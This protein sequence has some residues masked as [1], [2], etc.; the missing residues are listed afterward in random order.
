MLPRQV[1]T[2]K[3]NNDL[4]QSIAIYG[5]VS[6]ASTSSPLGK[7]RNWQGDSNCTLPYIRFLVFF[8]FSKNGVMRARGQDS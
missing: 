4:L 7:V 8:S 5:N 6:P 3:A 2:Q 1:W